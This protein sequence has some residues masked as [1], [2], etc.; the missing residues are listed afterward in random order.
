[1]ARRLR[2]EGL[3]GQTVTL[4]VRFGDF[5]TITR[6]A[7]FAAPVDTA[8]ALYR[9]AERMWGRVG[10]PKQPIRLLGI[11][12]SRLGR[13]AQVDL[14]GRGARQGRVDRVVD[15]INARF[16]EGTVKPARLAD[17]DGTG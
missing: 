9:A 14:F 10:P 16:G 13:A 5:R 7:T 11:S 2:A 4:K 17:A 15:S 12:M 3:L 1:M 6:S 8:G